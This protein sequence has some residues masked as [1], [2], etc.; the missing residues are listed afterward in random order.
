[1]TRERTA[2]VVRGRDWRQRP[3]V[4]FNLL[5]WRQRE[6][7]RLRLRRAAEWGAAALI[8]FACAA[9]LAGWQMWQRSRVE[10]R[11]VAVE[12]QAAQLREPFAQAQQLAR[13]IET[14]RS[15]AQL[16]I[17]R[18]RS[19][20]RAVVLIDSLASAGTA[21]VVLQRIAQHGEETELQA[22]VTSESVASTWLGHLR[23]IPDVETV[24]VREFKR[25]AQAANVKALARSGEPLHV[26]VRLGWRGA[27]PVKTAGRGL[28]DSIRNTK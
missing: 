10:A 1:M 4:G 11:R 27:A 15:A 17:E 7:R 12:A 2:R 20:K 21:G 25:T 8:G 19:L 18:G 3:V 26:V 23:A 5:P 13:V 24:N 28:R 16:S 22:A 14:R 6:I 9:P